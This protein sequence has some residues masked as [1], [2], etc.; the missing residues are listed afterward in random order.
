VLLVGIPVGVAAVAVPAVR[1]VLGR[2]AMAA[3]ASVPVLAM[4]GSLYFSERAGFVP[5]ELCWYQRIAMYPLAVILPIAAFRRDRS[6]LPYAAVVAVIGLCVSAY[7]VY[8]QAFPDESN[9]CEITNPCSAKWVEAYGW[10]TIPWMAGLSFVTILLGLT[11]VWLTSRNGDGRDDAGR[12]PER[13]DRE[14]Q[15][16]DV[17]GGE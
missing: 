14:L 2:F 12:T 1:A 4:A 11:T 6:V 3:T 17:D 8:I 16:A 5:C 15:S 10:I 7:H 13:D 9:F